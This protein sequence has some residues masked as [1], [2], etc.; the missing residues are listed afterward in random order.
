WEDAAAYANWAGKR[1]PTEAE[2]EKAARGAA[3][4]VFP[5]GNTFDPKKAALGEGSEGKA[6][7]L[8]E[9]GRFPAGASPYGCQDMCGNAWEWTADWY[10]RYKPE[11]PEA[12][13]SPG[14][15]H[16]SGIE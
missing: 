3:G 9:V 14:G 11:G 15:G 7:G 5:W 13:K 4:R 6:G 8:G 1:L 2:W 12:K 16:P 10:D